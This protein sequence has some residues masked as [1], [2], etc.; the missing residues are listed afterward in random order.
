MFVWLLEFC[1]VLFG[2]G[3]L[4]RP[5]SPFGVDRSCGI[6]WFEYN[7]NIQVS[8]AAVADLFADYFFKSFTFLLC[9]IYVVLILVGINL[10]GWATY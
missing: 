8:D 7:E 5:V 9:V 3:L 1:L 10:V 4:L 6:G 2:A